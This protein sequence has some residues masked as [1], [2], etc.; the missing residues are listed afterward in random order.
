KKMADWL[1]DYN[2]IIPHHGLHMKTPVQYLL[3]TNPQCHML[4][5]NTD[6]LHLRDF[7]VQSQIV[8]AYKIIPL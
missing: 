4:W 1:I 3:E 5:T 2:T 6:Y 8:L 7:W